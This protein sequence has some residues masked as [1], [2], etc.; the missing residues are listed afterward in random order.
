VLEWLQ[1]PEEKRPHFLCLYFSAVD[2]AGHQHGPDSP[3]VKEAVLEVDRWLADLRRGL[4]ELPFPVNMIVVSD[5][6]MEA[7]D[8]A[9]KEYLDDYTDLSGITL[10]D[11]GPQVLIYA[12]EKKKREKIYA[13]LKTKGKHFRVYRRQEL[14]AKWHYSASARVGDL[15]VVASAPYSIGIRDPRFKIPKGSHGYDPDEAKSMHGIFYAQGP[16]IKEGV[17]LEPFRNVDI[18]PFIL[19]ILGLPIPQKI[20]GNPGTLRKILKE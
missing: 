1:L 7:L 6:G 9:K 3:Q 19:K 14:P 10:G 5:H 16:Q 15:V 18:Y 13:D 8:E 20:D 4:E 17:T 12:P 2:S 11:L